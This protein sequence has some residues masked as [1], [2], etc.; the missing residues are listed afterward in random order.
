MK[1]FV[2]IAVFMISFFLVAQ[3]SKLK[4]AVM[5][6]EDK[7]QTLEDSVL[8][9]AADYMRGEFVS[10]GS[11][12]VIAKERQ[13]KEM[14]KQLKKE[15]HSICKD[16]NCQIPLGQA[17][18]ADTILRTTINYFGGIYTITTELIDLAK[19]ATVKGAKFKFDGSEQGLM[20]AMDRVVAKLSG[21]KRIKK[22]EKYVSEDKWTPV[23]SEEYMV[24][25]ESDPNGSVVMVDNKMLCTETPCSRMIEKGK[26]EIKFAIE[27]YETKKLL[28]N[29][30]KNM[31]IFEKLPSNYGE[32][33]VKSVP[34]SKK[35]YINGEE[36]GKT[37]LKLKLVPGTYELKVKNK[38]YL[39]SGWKVLIEKGISEERVADL[40]LRPSAIKVV[41][42]DEKGNALSGK[43][44]V[45]GKY[46]G[47]VPGTHKVPLCSKMAEI[48]TEKGREKKKLKLKEKSVSEIK[49]S[50]N[51]L[52]I[53]K[54]DDRFEVASI[55][56]VIPSN[57]GGCGSTIIIESESGK[58]V[59][60]KVVI[61]NKNNILWQYPR[62]DQS[63]LQFNSPEGYC[64]NLFY[65]GYNDW[66]L[67]SINELRT[68]VKDCNETKTGGTCGITNNCHEKSCRND[69]CD[70][71]EKKSD[72]SYSVFG[73]KAYLQ[74][75]TVSE[76]TDVSTRYWFLNFLSGEI[77][78]YSSRSWIEYSVRCVRDK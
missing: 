23:S 58:P 69:T 4:L 21:N 46:V 2:F 35:I 5:E 47:E 45:D 39:E 9:N 49:A 36:K 15:S 56:Y 54:I 19:E 31:D 62:T 3:E 57:V 24:K 48:V 14:I 44:Y 8:S 42:I 1:R 37:P 52:K 12:V 32:L 27:N 63:D 34:S 73:D 65:A 28:L 30:Y 68:L 13:E 11:F 53:K 67:P 51:S 59:V 38:C 77:E 7:S 55:S 33:L 78:S 18:S 20:K 76:V 16:K 17:L 43:L 74:S 41:A 64:E 6:I 61:D 22:E 25:F 72:N 70:G 66:R 10:S 75:S 40:K 26:H 50:F 60:E 29:V 71:C